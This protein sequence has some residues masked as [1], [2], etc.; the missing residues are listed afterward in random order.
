MCTDALY[1]QDRGV[2]IKKELIAMA[3]K[4]MNIYAKLEKAR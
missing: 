3:E 1:K 4:A 2:I